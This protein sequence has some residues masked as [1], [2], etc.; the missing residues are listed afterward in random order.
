MASVRHATRL[1]SSAR[2][3]S[4]QNCPDKATLAIHLGTLDWVGHNLRTGMP[5]EK[6]SRQEI[7]T[8]M[9]AQPQDYYLRVFDTSADAR[10]DELCAS[11]SGL[12]HEGL[13]E[14]AVGLADVP[15]TFVATVAHSGAT[16]TIHAGSSVLLT[17]MEGD[18]WSGVDLC[19]GVAIPMRFP[20]EAVAPITDAADMPD[21]SGLACW[22]PAWRR[23]A[24]FASH[25]HRHTHTRT[26]TR[27]HTLI[28]TG[29]PRHDAAA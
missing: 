12:G 20:A 14:A 26:H 22:G 28:R 9:A 21:A 2:L 17:S 13:L 16:A 5:S 3:F 15:E 8:A 11:L 4:T 24:V 10:A 7:E 23:P 29:L 6:G 25:A 19:T 1:F 18:T 27:T